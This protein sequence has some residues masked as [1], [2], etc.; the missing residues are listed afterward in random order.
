MRL[1]MRLA[2]KMGKT[3]QELYQTMSAYE[4][5]LWAAEYAQNPWGEEREDYRVGILASTIVNVSGKIVKRGNETKP[6]DFMPFQKKPEDEE[7]INVD[8]ATFLKSMGHG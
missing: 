1:L 3:I 5:S 6:H 4:F 8:P 2:L 7:F